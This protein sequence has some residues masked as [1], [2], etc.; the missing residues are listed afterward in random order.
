MLSLPTNTLT[1]HD[2]LMDLLLTVNNLLSGQE[3]DAGWISTCGGSHEHAG[4]SAMADLREPPARLYQFLFLW[5]ANEINC[6]RALP[7]FFELL[8]SSM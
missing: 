5:E 6:L 1:S 3:W 8:R 7:L 2:N 4:K